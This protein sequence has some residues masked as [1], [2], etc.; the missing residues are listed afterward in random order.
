MSADPDAAVHLGASAELVAGLLRDA[1]LDDVEILTVRGRQTGPWSGRRAG[2]EGAPTVLLYAHHDVQPVGARADWDTD[3]FEPT[4]RSGRLYGRG[5]ADD[6]A[7][8]AVHLAALRT[9]GPDL[10]VGVRRSRRGRGGDRI[11]DPAG[12]FWPP[13]GSGWPADVVVLADSS[14]WTVDIPALTTSLR[15]GAHVDVEVRTLDHGLHSGMYGGAAPDALTAL[16]RLLATLHDEAGNVAVEGLHSGTSAGPELSESQFRADAGLLDG[17]RLLGARGPVTDRLWNKPSLT[18]IGLDAPP[19]EGSSPTLTARWPGAPRSVCG[20]APGDDAGSAQRALVAHL[21]ANASWG[22][23]VTVT[24]H[25]TAAPYQARLEG[26]AY[27]AAHTAFAQAWGTPAVDTGTGGSIPF[28]AAFAAEL[29]D[30]EI[31]I[32]GVEDPDTRAH[33]AN[34]SLHL[35]MF[36]RCCLAEALLLATLGTG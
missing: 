33:G 23:T 21:Q 36:E 2:P 34:E 5:C 27:D 20:W 9:F 10:P 28:I 12:R 35:A 1:G 26:R 11:T 6:K 8:I 15:G 25:G 17:V 14:N 22:A 29:P 31:L 19:V 30:A 13:T 24:E 4:E 18:V 16:C 7:G 3:P 32:T